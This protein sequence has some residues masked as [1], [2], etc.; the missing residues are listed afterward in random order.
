[1]CTRIIIISYLPYVFCVYCYYFLLLIIKSYFWT[2]NQRKMN[3]NFC[4]IFILL[5]FSFLPPKPK[6]ESVE[7]NLLFSKTVTFIKTIFM[8][9]TLFFKSLIHLPFL[10]QKNENFPTY[11]IFNRLNPQDCKIIMKLQ[12]IQWSLYMITIDHDIFLYMYT[13]HYHDN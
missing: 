6:I 12:H 7:E 3:Q 10:L 13:I 8:N 2:K 5:K 9:K 11:I 4:L 1:M